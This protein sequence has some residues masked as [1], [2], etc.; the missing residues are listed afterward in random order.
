MS[1]SFLFLLTD[2]LIDKTELVKLYIMYWLLSICSIQES[3]KSLINIL[4]AK[5]FIA[6]ITDIMYKHLSGEND[7]CNEKTIYLFNYVINNFRLAFHDVK[8]NVVNHHSL[9]CVY[10]QCRCYPKILLIFDMITVCLHTRGT[11][12][13]I[14]A[15][16][17]HVIL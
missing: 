6:L 9:Q 8:M 2:Q 13:D 7:R 16:N 10:T 15:N 4:I 11:E 1:F 12:I 3:C 17:L 14:M 5:S